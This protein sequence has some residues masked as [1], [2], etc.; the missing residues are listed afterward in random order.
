M[1]FLVQASAAPV[2]LLALQLG[3]PLFLIVLAVIV[4]GSVER[5]HFRSLRRRE[6][7]LADVLVTNIKTFPGGVHESKV[8][9]LVSGNVVIA[10]DYLK[11]FLANLKKIVGGEL[12][13]YETL[14]ERSRR[15]ALLRLLEEAR[16]RGFDAVCN[17]RF[18]SADVGGMTGKRGAA[19]VEVY[20]YATAY[21]RAPSQG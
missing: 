7:E 1:S 10:T 12:K 15:E 19:M 14:L 5:A 6:K 17:L 2:F 8:P 16:S 13:S 11:T 21:R 18:E 9:A 3:I 4:G 20:A